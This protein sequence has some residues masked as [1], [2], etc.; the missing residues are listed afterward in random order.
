MALTATGHGRQKD[1]L[2]AVADLGL[3]PVSR[4]DVLAADVDVHER[5]ELPVLEE[6]TRKR[7]VP[8]DEVLD[9]FG[10]SCAVGL[11]LAGATDLGAQCRRD[12]NRG[13][14]SPTVSSAPRDAA[15][16]LQNS[17]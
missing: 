17:T 5:S 10:D 7:R 11:E 2:I 3:E 6:L 1:Q 8:L 12:A 13:H 15:D 4:P 14:Q 16:A 9:D